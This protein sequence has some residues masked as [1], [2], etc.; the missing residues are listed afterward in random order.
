MMLFCG[1]GLSRKKI[2]ALTHHSYG[3]VSIV[4]FDLTISLIYKTI[5]IRSIWNAFAGYCLAVSQIAEFT[6][7]AIDIGA[8]RVDRG[9]VLTCVYGAARAT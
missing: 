2:A 1:N 6:S 5:V 7:N 4:G 8:E 9:G 3:L